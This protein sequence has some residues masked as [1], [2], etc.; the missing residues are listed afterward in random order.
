MEVENTMA[1]VTHR[2]TSH[3]KGP[4]ALSLAQEFELLEPEEF[5]QTGKK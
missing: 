2:P 1:K 3:S 5:A 4:P